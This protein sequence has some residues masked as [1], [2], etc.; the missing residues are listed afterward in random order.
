MKE[1]LKIHFQKNMML[2]LTEQNSSLINCAIDGIML[3]TTKFLKILL[4]GTIKIRI[5]GKYHMNKQLYQ[6]QTGTMLWRDSLKLLQS[7]PFSGMVHSPV[8]R[9]QGLNFGSQIFNQLMSRRGLWEGHVPQALQDVEGM[10]VTLSTPC[11]L[12]QITLL[13]SISLVL[14]CDLDINEANSYNVSRLIMERE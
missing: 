1:T 6:S 7:F 4:Y 12:N 5:C 13:G 2:A 11:I 3:P 14:D 9:T 8:S 10:N